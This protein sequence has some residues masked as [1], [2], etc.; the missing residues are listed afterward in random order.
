MMEQTNKYCIMVTECNK[1]VVS[2]YTYLRG[3]F[4]IHT[5][6]NTGGRTNE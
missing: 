6:L 2:M 5:Q 4:K 3:Y 1:K